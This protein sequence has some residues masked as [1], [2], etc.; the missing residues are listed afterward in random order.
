M[1]GRREGGERERRCSETSLRRMG[2]ADDGQEHMTAILPSPDGINSKPCIPAT[3]SLHCPVLLK[4]PH[5]LAP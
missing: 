2:K 5:T 4:W 1:R 3:T